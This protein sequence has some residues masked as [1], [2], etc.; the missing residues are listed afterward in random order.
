[1]R[2]LANATCAGTLEN[3]YESWHQ[4]CNHFPAC[5][6]LRTSKDSIHMKRVGVREVEETIVRKA[7]SAEENTVGQMAK[8]YLA[9]NRWAVLQGLP[10]LC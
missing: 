9:K 2:V 1:M 8:P 6:L 4:C 7:R 10:S 5:K 3:L